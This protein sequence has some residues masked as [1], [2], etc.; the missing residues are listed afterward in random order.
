MKNLTVH[1]KLDT[2]LELVYDMW[3]NENLYIT[4]RFQEELDADLNTNRLTLIG[5]PSEDTKELSVGLA[6]CS[7][8]D[9]FSRTKGTELAT[10]N[11]RQ[12]PYKVFQIEEF[13]QENCLE[14]LYILHNHL[15][16][17]STKE[18]KRLINGLK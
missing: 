13:N 8:P 4:S 3:S 7:F 5:I 15:I 2:G 12:N 9:N 14:V 11:A 17:K 18:V 1:T 6:F 16:T 10:F